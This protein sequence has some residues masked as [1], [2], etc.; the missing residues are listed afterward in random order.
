MWWSREEAKPVSGP[1]HFYIFFNA[2][3]ITTCVP[4][5]NKTAPK[6]GMEVIRSV[7]KVKDEEYLGLNWGE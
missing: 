3:W 1:H 4:R 7:W 5:R 6:S 2:N